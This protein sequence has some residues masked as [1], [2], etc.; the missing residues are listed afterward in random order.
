V[1]AVVVDIG[2]S[3]LRAGYAGDDIPKAI[4]PSYYGYKTTAGD[5]DVQM[6]ETA[7][8]NGETIP[9]PPSDAKLYLGQNGPSI[10][11]EGMEIGNPVR[12]ASSE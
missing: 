1:S 8:E 11:R 4:V 2:S 3:S 5:S 6:G 9:K 7:L 12:D 10:W